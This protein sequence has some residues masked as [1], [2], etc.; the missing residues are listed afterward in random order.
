MIRQG[1]G[2]WGRISDTDSLPGPPRGWF[3]PLCVA[4]CAAEGFL[5]LCLSDRHT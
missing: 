2:L 4:A 3:Y 1:Q 5:D